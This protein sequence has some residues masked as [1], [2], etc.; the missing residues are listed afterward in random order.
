M[1]N[2]LNDILKN[3]A[4]KFKSAIAVKELNGN[5]ASYA[6]LN[7][8][9]K[10]IRELLSVNSISSGDRVGIIGPKSINYLAAIFGIAESNAAYVPIDMHAPLSR[11]SS[12]IN[13]C[14]LKAI[15]IF[16]GIIEQYENVFSADCPY[17]I[18][19]FDSEFSL[20][21]LKNK[22]KKHNTNLAYILYTS[23]STGTPKGVM[24]THESA[25]AFIKW[26]IKKFKPMASDVFCSNAP[27]HFDL[28]VFDIFVPLCVGASVVLFNEDIASNPLKLSYELFQNKITY[29]YAT[30]TA[31]TYL[32]TYGKLQ[33]YNYASLKC[34]LF[35]GEVFPI[36]DL[37]KLKEIWSHVKFHNLYGPTETNVCSYYSIPHKIPKNQTEPFPIGK[38]C[39]FAFLKINDGKKMTGELLVAGTSVMQG[40]WNDRKKTAKAFK[41]E[42][43]K[44]W[45]KTGD[46][47][48]VNPDGDFM[49]ISRKDRMVKRRGYRIE[50]GEIEVSLCKHP[51]VLLAAVCVETGD[52][53]HCK[54]IAHLTLKKGSSLSEADFYHYS[55]II[56]PGYMTPDR[57]I[58]HKRLPLTSTQKIDYKTLSSLHE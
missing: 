28:S 40:Y 34:V 24:H 55:K 36:N 33:K 45:Y 21:I 2:N 8:R 37:R 51:D 13:D 25:L 56:L 18:E 9:A 47:V 31:L 4:A 16:N 50:L 11:N 20:I 54:I 38:A 35:A 19:K 1:F 12:V 39:S 5:T 14:D 49:Y 57:F 10:K 17:S 27:F 29:F 42:Q 3:G 53:N 6:Q 30:P 41:S 44:L 58:F 48:S 23:G 52:T 43:G 32:F 22:I 46:I 26:S 15:F 7:D